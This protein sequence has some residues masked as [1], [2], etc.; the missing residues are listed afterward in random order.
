MAKKT[1]TQL[2]V[3]KGIKEDKAIELIEQ[4]GLDADDPDDLKFITVGAMRDANV[5]SGLVRKYAQKLGLGDPDEARVVSSPPAT[6]T[7]GSD[8]NLALAIVAQATGVDMEAVNDPIKDI[9][10]CLRRL[11]DAT[12]E[13][14]QRLVDYLGSRKLGSSSQPVLVVAFLDGEPVAEVTVE[15]NTS[16]SFNRA[17]AQKY[18]N[19]GLDNGSVF[20]EFRWATLAGLWEDKVLTWHSSFDGSVVTLLGSVKT[21]KDGTTSVRS[22]SIVVNRRMSAWRSCAT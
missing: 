1:L 18:V 14:R 11:K 12:P 20:Y 22:S 13:N 5:K 7:P 10:D 4:L 9:A 15:I 19:K 21:A 3:S 17:A 16:P 2:L 8:N 6:A